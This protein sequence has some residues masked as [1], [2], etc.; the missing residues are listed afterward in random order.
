MT[1][2][3]DPPHGG[4]L[5]YPTGQYQWLGQNRDDF[6]TKKGHPI[7]FVQWDGPFYL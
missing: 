6:R 7:A 5:A 3:I 2:E 1:L 4:T